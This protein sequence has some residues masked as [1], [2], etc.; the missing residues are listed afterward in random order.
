MLCYPSDPDFTTVILTLMYRRSPFE[1]AGG[2]TQHNRSMRRVVCFDDWFPRPGSWSTWHCFDSVHPMSSSRIV[3]S[4]TLDAPTQNSVRCSN[5]RAVLISLRVEK[6]ERRRKSIER[7]QTPKLTKQQRTDMC[8]TK[9]RW[10]TWRLSYSS[11]S[12]SAPTPRAH[13]TV[14]RQSS[15]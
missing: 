7:F 4:M 13:T 12:S 5:F 1:S 11:S 10:W 14:C 9:R 6:R 3:Y 15:P 8:G 2:K